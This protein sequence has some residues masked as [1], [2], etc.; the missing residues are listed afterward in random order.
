MT[1]GN[2]EID[3]GRVE[4]ETSIWQNKTFLIGLFA[5]VGSAILIL[6]VVVICLK[7]RPKVIEKEAPLDC[8][9]THS[10][11]HN[12]MYNTHRV[13]IIYV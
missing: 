11:Y 2:I 8:K 4:F 7:R 12:Y 9:K 5:G 3:Y 13:I 10:V 1:V 6:V